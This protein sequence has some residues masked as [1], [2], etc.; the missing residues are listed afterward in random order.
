MKSC[1]KCGTELIDQA[2][3]CPHC[4]AS[5]S[6]D[7]LV[8]VAVM[9][10]LGIVCGVAGVALLVYAEQIDVDPHPYVS[11]ILAGVLLL[12]GFIMFCRKWAKRS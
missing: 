12:V 5:Q 4:G 2:F 9:K 6:L 7:A 8:S 1:S 3:Y 10:F 11:W